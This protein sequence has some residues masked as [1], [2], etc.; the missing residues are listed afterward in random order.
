MKGK[1]T[2]FAYFEMQFIL[3]WL[4]GSGLK[5]MNDDMPFIH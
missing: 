3:D 2:L 1:K 4:L 5:V